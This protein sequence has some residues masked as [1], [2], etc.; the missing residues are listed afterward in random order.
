MNL[1]PRPDFLSILN[2]EKPDVSVLTDYV[3][4][5]LLTVLDIHLFLFRRECVGTCGPNYDVIWCKNTV[6]QR[7]NEV[8][9]FAMSSFRSH[10]SIQKTGQNAAFFV[11]SSAHTAYCVS[12]YTLNELFDA[13]NNRK[14]LSRV[15]AVFLRGYISVSN[16]ARYIL[17]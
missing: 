2:L 9:S 3:L 16:R 17:H 6:A 15:T 10:H 1:F 12:L 14:I 5:S 13:Y 4:C 11:P 8:W 7:I